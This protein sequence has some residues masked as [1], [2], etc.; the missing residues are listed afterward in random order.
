MHTARSLTASP[1][2]LCS[3]DGG[4][5]PGPGGGC[6][7]QEGWYPSMHWGRPPLV[8]RITDACENIILPQSSLLSVKR[9]KLKEQMTNIK[10]KVPFRFLSVCMGLYCYANYACKRRTR[11]DFDYCSFHSEFFT[12]KK[13]KTK[14]SCVSFY[15]YIKYFKHVFFVYVHFSISREYLIQ[16]MVSLSHSTQ[17]HELATKK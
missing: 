8:N 9:K 11:I 5:L 7:V 2:M 6:L 10:E 17:I 4:C 12:S 16:L 13:Q 14:I 1:H 15:L 3:G